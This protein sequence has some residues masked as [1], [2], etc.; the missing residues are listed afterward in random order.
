MGLFNKKKKKPAA[1]SAAK[2]AEK[3]AEKP[4]P[5]EKPKKPEP[6]KLCPFLGR[7]CEQVKCAMWIEGAEVLRGEKLTLLGDVCAL[8]WDVV[9]NKIMG[10][11]MILD[12]PILLKK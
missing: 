6:A 12:K 10:E 8:Y 2:P 11:T 3:P 4:K 9:R 5:V 1:S 7:D